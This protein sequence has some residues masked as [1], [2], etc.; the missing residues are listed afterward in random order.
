MKRKVTRREEKGVK[1]MSDKKW[2]KGYE[3]KK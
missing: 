1:K 2:R 3:T